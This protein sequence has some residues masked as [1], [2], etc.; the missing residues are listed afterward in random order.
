MLNDLRNGFTEGRALSPPIAFEQSVAALGRGIDAF[1]MDGGARGLGEE[2][3]FHLYALRF[4]LSRLAA[5]MRA[6]A[7]ELAITPETA[8]N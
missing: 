5:D 3:V 7:N 6:L 8:G 1:A 2:G 4:A